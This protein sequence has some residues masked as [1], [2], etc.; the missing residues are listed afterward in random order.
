[1]TKLGSIIAASLVCAVLAGCGTKPEDVASDFIDAMCAKDYSKA[2]ELTSPD[3]IS[4]I[5]LQVRID[6]RDTRKE[7]EEFFGSIKSY[8]INKV[9][10][11]GDFSIVAFD[12]TFENGNTEERFVIIHSGDDD[13]VK[14]AIPGLYS[15]EQLAR[16]PYIFN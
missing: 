16:L 11:T 7:T 8:S 6:T 3:V 10:K 4:Q 14:V 9:A 15:D 5:W 12:V 1:M 2:S 13:G